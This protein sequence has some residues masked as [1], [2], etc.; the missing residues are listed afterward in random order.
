MAHVLAKEKAVSVKQSPATPHMAVPASRTATACS[1]APIAPAANPAAVGLVPVVA[2]ATE[3][4]PSLAGTPPTL[5][6]VARLAGVSSRLE[7][8]CMRR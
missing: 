6:Y 7:T 3:A 5:A 4:Q 2:S 1:D 8:R